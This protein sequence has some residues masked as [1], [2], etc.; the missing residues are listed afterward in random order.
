MG[1]VKI[2]SFRIYRYALD[3]NRHITVHGNA[4]TKREGL[5]L[6]L[7]SDSGC[8]SF[9]EIA[10]L[11]GFSRE[12]LNDAIDQAQL[13]KSKMNGHAV[14]EGLT[15]FDGLFDRWFRVYELKPSVRFGIE[16]AVLQL[17]AASQN[18]PFCQIIPEANSSKVQIT[19]LLSGTKFQVKNQA[20][21]F[22]EDGLTDLKLKVGGLVEDDIEKVRAVNEATLGKALLHL[23]ANQLWE[24]DQAVAFGEAIGCSAATYIEEPFKNCEQVPEFFD[25]TLIP[26]A[27]DESL[28]DLSVEEARSISGVERVVIKPTVLGGVEK[29]LKMVVEAELYALD[30]VISSSME[31]SVGIWALAN[32]GVA[33]KHH[34]AV[35]LDTL[36]FFDK[37][38][39]EKPIPIEHGWIDVAEPVIRPENIRFDMLD[40]I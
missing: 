34:T 20:K 10:P 27:L 28:Q 16:S 12:N 5:I 11:P 37:D 9:G 21:Q 25:R 29:A 26:V 18:E 35:G 3:F 2:V 24:F 14:L 4:M 13:L 22:L 30:A 7:K 19:G 39:V 36:K 23:D 40:E 15:R 1:A 8:E 33:S 17:V 38:I 6:H 32:L 31:T